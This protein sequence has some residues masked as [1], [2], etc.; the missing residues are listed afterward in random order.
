MFGLKKG[1][2][3]NQTLRHV[4]LC[5]K[6][7]ACMAVVDVT[8]QFGSQNK[9]QNSFPSITGNNK[10]LT[11]R[12]V[13]SRIYYSDNKGFIIRSEFYG[14]VMSD[15]QRISKAIKKILRG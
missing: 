4:V 12:K 14:L 11:E 2:T 9:S 10:T 3:L 5:N 8:A 7:C 13:Q 15:L 6:G 1:L